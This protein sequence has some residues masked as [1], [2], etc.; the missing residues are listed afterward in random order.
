MLEVINKILIIFTNLYGLYFIVTALS[1]F[2]KEKKKEN[3]NKYKNYFSIL[4]PARN[5]EKVI[6]NLINSL[7]N[8]NYDK[9]KYEINVILNNSKDNT[10]NVST[11]AGANVLRCKSK[12]TTKGEALKE[13]FRKINDDKID[14]YIIFDADNVVDKDFLK[15]MN[16]SINNGYKVAQGFRDTKN[17]KC[18]WIS[19][20]YTIYYFIQNLFYNKS[21]KKL[22][23][24]ASINGTGFMIKKEVIDTIGFNVKTLSE[25]VEFTGIC[26]LNDIKIDFVEKAVTYDE[27]ASDFKISWIQRKRWSKGCL[28]CYKNYSHELYKN[29]KNNKSCLDLAMMYMAPMVQD[30]ALIMLGISAVNKILSKEVLFTKESIITSVIFS[31]AMYLAQ[32]ILSTFVILIN[33]K[34]LK[35]YLSG[36][37]LF[38]VFIITW[39]P[40]NIIILFQKNIKWK[41]IPHNKNI[42]IDEV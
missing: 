15:Y 6:A 14:A 26:A 37:L 27:Q 2:K 30:I 17:D 40:I 41:H 23:R 18:N 20:S 35:K 13:A 1:I 42:T 39:L 22:N 9:D 38:P 34:P 32:V 3:K 4:I 19:S 31:I 33:K 25:D 28:D 29:T 36:I 16:E 5:E 11:N 21:R 12:I 7:N 24:S 8:M 10:Y